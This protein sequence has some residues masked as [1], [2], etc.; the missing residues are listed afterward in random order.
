MIGEGDAYLNHTNSRLLH[1]GKQLP[2]YRLRD[3]NLEAFATGAGK[4]SANRSRS[5]YGVSPNLPTCPY[6]TR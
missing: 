3:P 4:A 1:V 6:C 5:M 2:A